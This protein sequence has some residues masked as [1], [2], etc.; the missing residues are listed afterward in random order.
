MLI[1]EDADD[2]GSSED[3]RDAGEAASV[4]ELESFGFALF[5]DMSVDARVTKGLVDGG[6]SGFEEDGG[7]FGDEFPV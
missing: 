5:S 1:G 2:A 4:E 3:G 7:E 6:A